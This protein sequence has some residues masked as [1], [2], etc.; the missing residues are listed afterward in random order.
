MNELEKIV[1][2]VSEKLGVR[3]GFREESSAEKKRGV[4]FG[5]AFRRK[6]HLFPL[7]FRGGNVYGRSGRSFESGEELR[8]AAARLSYFVCGKKRRIAGR[9]SEKNAARRIFADG[10]V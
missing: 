6:A 4:F 1:T 9:V 10:R 3:L 2:D 8:R 5:A 7:F